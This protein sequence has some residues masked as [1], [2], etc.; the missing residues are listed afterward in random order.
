VFGVLAGADRVCV[1]WLGGRIVAGKY[2]YGVPVL[3]STIG[4]LQPPA[5]RGAPPGEKAL[6]D[7]EGVLTQRWAHA[8][9][10]LATEAAGV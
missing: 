2:P 7:G 1:G 5:G 9:C 3:A 10:G 8:S 6:R 4:E